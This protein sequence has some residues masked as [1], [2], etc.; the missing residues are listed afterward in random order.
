MVDRE[1]EQEEAAENSSS[2]SDAARS[3]AELLQRRPGHCPLGHK[4]N[5]W[6]AQKGHCDG[7]GRVVRGGERVMDCRNCNFYLC[8]RCLPKAYEEGL[9]GALTYLADVAAQEMSEV[10]AE[11]SALG[12]R[13]HC[14]A[15]TKANLTSEELQVSPE[16]EPITGAAQ[17]EEW[18]AGGHR[19]GP[20]EAMPQPKESMIEGKAAIE[21]PAA[22]DPPDLIEFADDLMNFT[23][24]APSAASTM[25]GQRTNLLAAS[26][27][28]PAMLASPV[29]NLAMPAG[30]RDAKARAG[31][32]VP[33]GP[34]PVLAHA[35]WAP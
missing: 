10:A 16:T 28:P 11:L 3:T 35:G 21:R 32:A 27:G 25:G 8:G 2:S 23:S 22:M 9:W 5:P 12:A 6:I 13:A 33:N 29:G 26:A 18:P 1:Q 4:L 15:P 24:P 31:P 20:E 34:Q 30:P 19:L 17:P 14:G 7:C